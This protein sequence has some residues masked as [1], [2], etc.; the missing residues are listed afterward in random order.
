MVVV[1]MVADMAAAE[2]VDADVAVTEVN[3]CLIS[4]FLLCLHNYRR[5]WSSR[6]FNLLSGRGG[7]GDRGGRGGFTPRGRGGPPRGRGGP[8]RGGPRGGFGG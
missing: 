5:E 2:E 1:D 6:S 3:I 7:Y 4:Y 8:P